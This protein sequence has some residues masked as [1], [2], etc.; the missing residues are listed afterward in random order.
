MLRSLAL[1]GTIATL[2]TPAFSDSSPYGASAG[3][4]APMERKS[5]MVVD[6]DDHL[7]ALI[8]NTP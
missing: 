3:K 8:E 5:R 2:A 6:E 4:S 7:A 1:L